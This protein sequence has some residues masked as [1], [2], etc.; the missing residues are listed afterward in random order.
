MLSWLQRNYDHLVIICS[1]SGKIKLFLS[2]LTYSREVR[3]L[4]CRVFNQ[5]AEDVSQHLSQQA[6]AHLQQQQEDLQRQLIQQQQQLQK[7]IQE[8]QQQLQEQLSQHHQFAIQYGVNQGFQGVKT[9]NGNESEKLHTDD[10]EMKH[11]L[12]EQPPQ[13][14]PLN[15][16]TTSV[17]HSTVHTS[18]VS[19][20]GQFSVCCG[21]VKV[22]YF[23][24][25]FF[26]IFSRSCFLKQSDLSSHYSVCMFD[27]LIAWLIACLFV[28]SYAN[29]LQQ[30]AHGIF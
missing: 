4:C 19:V 22:Y 25:C 6:A 11:V 12:T 7:Q 5:V 13:Q 9:E 2:K 29:Y 21:Q 18:T 17:H 27:C 28:D 16:A 20:S 14:Q 26:F 10:Q 15:L 1:N 8:Q 23:C 30:V 3:G 24:F